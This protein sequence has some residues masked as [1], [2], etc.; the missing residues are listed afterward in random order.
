[1]NDV[2]LK[3][4]CGRVSRAVTKAGRRPAGFTLIELLVVSAIIGILASLLLPGLSKAK[5]KARQ[6]SCLS[7]MKQLQLCWQMYALD[8]NRLPENYYFDPAGQINSNTWIRGS[9]DDNPAYGRVEQ[10]VLDSTNQNTIIS[11][12]LFSYNQSTGIYRCPSDRSITQGMP[13]VRS[14]SMNGWMGGQPLA[15]QDQFRV[16]RKETDITDPSPSQAFVFIDEHEKSINDG[17]FA[18]DM[19]GNRGFLDAPATRHDGRY[20]LSFADGHAETWKLR[21]DRTL[22]W[23]RLPIPNLPL[24]PDWDRLRAASSSAF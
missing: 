16:F 22:N 1:M 20:T 19:V 17:W 13:R 18:V 23:A 11:G 6:I 5:V 15:G 2:F 3:S 7:Q 24:N 9:M 8:H 4:G 12:K 10:G 21:D 14:Y